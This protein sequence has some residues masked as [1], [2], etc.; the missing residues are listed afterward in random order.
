MDPGTRLEHIAI[1]VD[2]LEAAVS[3][4][5]SILGR[6]DSGR[7][8]VKSEQ[9]NVAFFELDGPRIELLEPTTEDSAVG[10]F[11]ERRGPGLHHI[12]LEVHDI[13]AALARCRAAGVETVGKAPRAG[14]GGSRVAFLHPGSTGGVLIELCERPN[15][16]TEP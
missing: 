16:I 9:V 3:V 6:P 7:E 11:L 12:A 15:P 14:A 10:R 5:A 2:N 4:I 1:A 13:E 8:T